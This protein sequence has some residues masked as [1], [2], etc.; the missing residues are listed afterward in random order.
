MLKQHQMVRYVD[1]PFPDGK[2][3]QSLGAVVQQTV[4]DGRV[5]ALYVGHSPDN[6]WVVYDG[7]SD[8]DA[9]GAVVAVHISHVVDRDPTLA[10]LATLPVGYEADRE[11]VGAPWIIKPF[12]WGDDDE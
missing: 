4:L 8:P 3:P 7:V 11:A 10:E 5:P 1:F 2:F 6:D 9:D 12:E